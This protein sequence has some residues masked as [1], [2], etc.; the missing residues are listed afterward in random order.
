MT[1]ALP[2]RALPSRALPSRALLLISEYSKP[3]TR[4]DW[5]NSKPIITT[6]SLFSRVYYIR[7]YVQINM[8]PPSKYALDYILL[9]NILQTNW[10]YKYK[11]KINKLM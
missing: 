5:K 10:Y 9:C 3:M 7:H 6:Y 4:P 11:H 8:S 1:H 2:C